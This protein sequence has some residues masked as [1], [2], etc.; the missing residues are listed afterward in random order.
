MVALGQHLRADQAAAPRRDARAQ[1]FL[2]C[3]AA[4]HGVAIHA[5]ERHAGKHVLQAFP[6]CVRCLVRQ[7]LLP[8]H[9]RDTA[10]GIGCCVPQWW[11]ASVP[12][13]LM[14]RQSRIAARTRRDPAA[15]GTE[16]RRRIAAAV[17]VQQHLAAGA[18][19]PMDG[20]HRR[21]R[22][23]LR[24]RHACAGRRVAAP[25]AWLPPVRLGNS[26]MLRASRAD[27]LQAF[28]RGRGRAEHDRHAVA[29][30]HGPARGR[31]PSNESRPA[32]CTK[33]RALRRRRSVP[34]E[35]A[36]RRPP[37]ACR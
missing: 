32:A 10:A 23:S 24:T 35:P 27:S 8:R 21:R 15:V 37:S 28:Q 3:A 30:A 29:L 16:Q 7:A 22:D 36:A 33:H 5:C 19:M 4:A 2:Q 26:S 12:L 1:R 17:Q 13:A 9:S 25:V 14:H 18:K 34:A 31:G 20:K 6:R 11:Q